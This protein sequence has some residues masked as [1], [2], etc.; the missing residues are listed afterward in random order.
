MTDIEHYLFNLKGDTF[1]VDGHQV[2]IFKTF[3]R[4]IVACPW[5]RSSVPNEN[6][7]AYVRNKTECVVKYLKDEGFIAMDA[8]MQILVLT[9]H[10]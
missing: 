10:K 6:T 1:K 7:E 8:N 3:C 9:S 4:L 2:I 5:P